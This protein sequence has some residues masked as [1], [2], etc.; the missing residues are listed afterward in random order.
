MYFKAM[1]YLFRLTHKVSE[2]AKITTGYFNILEL[3]LIHLK[4]LKYCKTAKKIF[5]QTSTTIKTLEKVFYTVTIP[6]L[7]KR[8]FYMFLTILLYYSAEILFLNY[9]KM[10]Q[11]L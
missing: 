3:F 1:L 6:W 10:S 2:D 5:S 7:R 11:M 9:Y 8:F 4:T